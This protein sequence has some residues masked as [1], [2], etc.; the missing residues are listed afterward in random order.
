MNPPPFPI[1]LLRNPSPPEYSVER[2]ASSCTPSMLY[3]RWEGRILRQ[4]CDLNILEIHLSVAPVWEN[5]LKVFVEFPSISIA[6][7]VIAEHLA[8]IIEATGTCHSVDGV[9]H[10]FVVPVMEP[11]LIQSLENL[12]FLCFELGIVVLIER[13]T[14]C[15]YYFEIGSCLPC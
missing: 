9:I 12:F 3:H 5:C 11:A 4:T 7:H 6:E 13:L 1:T 14:H 15:A 10:G 8:E 2:R